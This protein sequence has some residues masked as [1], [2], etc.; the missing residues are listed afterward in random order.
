[1]Y[2]PISLPFLLKKHCY[3]VIEL[4]L[5]K[6]KC[7]ILSKRKKEKKEKLYIRFKLT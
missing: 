2:V 3:L 7:E 5:L 6:F 4:T 1:M